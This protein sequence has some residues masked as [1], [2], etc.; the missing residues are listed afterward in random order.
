MI[1]FLLLVSMLYDAPWPDY[2]LPKVHLKR[3]SPNYMEIRGEV[4]DIIDFVERVDD[5]IIPGWR[6]WH[7]MQIAHEMRKTMI[8]RRG[9]HTMY[10]GRHYKVFYECLTTQR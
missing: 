7:Y 5:K 1:V 4:D 6:S 9:Y 8:Y 10:I 3:I 2:Q